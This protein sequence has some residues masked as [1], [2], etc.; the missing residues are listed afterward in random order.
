M[1]SVMVLALFGNRRAQ[2]I[3][4]RFGCNGADIQGHTP[5]LPVKE[6]LL[7]WGTAGR[8]SHNKYVVVLHI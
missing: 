6:F 3:Q 2:R 8:E 5:A 7:P 4:V 1:I